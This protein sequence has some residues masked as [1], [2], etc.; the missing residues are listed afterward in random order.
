[1]KASNDGDADDGAAP[2]APTGN[3]QQV[4]LAQSGPAGTLL[5]IAVK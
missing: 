4:P 5:N 1:M 2:S 3:V